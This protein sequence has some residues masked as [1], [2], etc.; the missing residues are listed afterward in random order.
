M[1]KLFK[2]TDKEK[3][4][5]NWFVANSED[6]YDFKKDQERLFNILLNKL[7]EVNPDL[8]FQFSI[9]LKDGKREFIISA[10]G[11]RESFPSVFKLIEKAPVISK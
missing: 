3:E 2:K 9:D 8:S 1:F 11:I 4:F 6:Y 7:S 5:W 10:N